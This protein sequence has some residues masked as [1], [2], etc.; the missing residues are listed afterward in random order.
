MGMVD[1]TEVMGTN[2]WI[3]PPQLT[4]IERYAMYYLEASLEEVSKEELK[5]AEVSDRST[6]PSPHN[7]S[8]ALMGV[9]LSFPSGA[10]RS[11]P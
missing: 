1:C 10:G 7:G 6:S 2:S 4:P 11:C 3:P 9:F 5:Q 8:S